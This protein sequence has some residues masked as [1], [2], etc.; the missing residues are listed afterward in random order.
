MTHDAGM[1]CGIHSVEAYALE[2]TTQGVHLKAL[3]CTYC[4]GS[5]LIRLLEHYYSIIIPHKIT[6]TSVSV[7]TCNKIYNYIN[8]K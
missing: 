3:R 6:R 7:E 1:T 8:Y 5:H 2:N 4:Q